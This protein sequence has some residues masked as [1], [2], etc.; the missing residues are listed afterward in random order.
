[1]LFEYFIYRH[2]FVSRAVDDIH[3]DGI[4]RYMYKNVTE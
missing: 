1:M 2:Y 4:T 3:V